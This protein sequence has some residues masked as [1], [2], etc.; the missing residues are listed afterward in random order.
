MRTEEYYDDTVAYAGDR[1]SSRRRT[2]ST[3]KDSQ[4]EDGQDLVHMR[5]VGAKARQN[6]SVGLMKVSID[7]LP[8]KCLLGSSPR[9]IGYSRAS[10]IDRWVC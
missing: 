1:A 7:L 3:S 6:R 8:R 9:G 5:R 4:L 10:S 2:A